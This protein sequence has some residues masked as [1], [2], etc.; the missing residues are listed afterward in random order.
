[1][2]VDKYSSTRALL[3]NFLRA[4]ISDCRIHEAVSLEEG[5]SYC[6]PIPIQLAILSDRLSELEHAGRNRD[7]PPVVQRFANQVTCLVV[8]SHHQPQH[9]SGLQAMG[10]RHILPNPYTASQ[11]AEMVEQVAPARRLRNQPRFHLPHT[12]AQLHLGQHTLHAL[13]VNVS[14]S[15]VLC[16]VALS[17]DTPPT[18]SFDAFAQLAISLHLPPALKVPVQEHL[19]CR[20]VGMKVLEW[21]ENNLPALLRLEVK[22]RTEMIHNF[23]QLSHTLLLME[24]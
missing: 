16:E 13:V 11:L 20:L 15:G 5:L 6:N 2:I 24:E 4:E 17:A 22:L 8:L 9:V 12:T 21:H 1:M 14:P 18:F 10:F 23:A 3:K 7:I 19:A